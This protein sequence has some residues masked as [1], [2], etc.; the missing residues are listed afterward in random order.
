MKHG[1]G[2]RAQSSWC[3]LFYLIALKQC[4]RL[5]GQGWLCHQPGVALGV[6]GAWQAAAATKRPFGLGNRVTGP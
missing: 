4:A 3:R 1:R 2:A 5:A 6:P